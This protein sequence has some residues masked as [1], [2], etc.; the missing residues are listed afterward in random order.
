LSNQVGSWGQLQEWL[1][2]D[3]DEPGNQHRHLSH[4]YALF[5]GSE[6]T[7]RKTPGLYEAAVKSLDSR[8]DEGSGW[9]L[10][11]KIALRTRTE[12]GNHAYRLLKKYFHESLNSNLFAIYNNKFQI[13]SNFG[14]TAAIAEM[15]LQSHDNTLHFLPALPDA[16]EHGKVTGLKARGGY[17]ID[18]EWEGG[19]LTS[20]TIRKLNKQPLPLVMLAGKVVDPL[21]NGKFNIIEGRTGK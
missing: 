11:W 3:K 8:G 2:E 7:K 9:T 19:E 10:A 4:L 13:E 14:T 20:T 16:W 12:D 1:L 15:L 18:I 5:P 21:K 17:E 6:I